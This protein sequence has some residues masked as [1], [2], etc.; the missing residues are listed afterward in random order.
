MTFRL[1]LIIEWFIIAFLA[2]AVVIALLQWDVTASFD[3]LLYDGLSETARPPVDEDIIIIAIDDASLKEFGKWPWGR[4]QH[5]KTIENIKKLGPRSISLDI[6]LSET[7]DIESDTLLSTAL[8]G[9]MQTQVADI[10]APAIFL[11]LHFVTPGNEGRAFDTILPAAPFLKRGNK[12][13]NLGHVNL[14]FDNDGI[15]RKNNICF[16]ASENSPQWPHLMERIYQNRHGKPSPAMEKAVK[17]TLCDAPVLIPFSESGSIATLSYSDA[18]KGNIL[19]EFVRGKDVIIG[20]TAAGLGDNYPTPSSN[21]SL[22]PGVEII[23]NMLG[24]LERDDFITPLPLWQSAL[25]SLLLIW[26]LLIGFLRWQPRLILIASGVIFFAILILSATFLY[27]GYWFPPGPALAALLLAYPLW[28]WRRLQAISYYMSEKLRELEREEDSSPLGLIQKKSIDLVGK[29]RDTLDQ[30]IDNIRDLRRFVNDTLFGLPDPMFVVNMDN[31]VILSNDILNQRIDSD[32]MGGDLS[33][34]IDTLVRKEDRA[35]VWQYIE[36][37]DV[38]SANAIIDQETVVR[39]TDNY[40]SSYVRFTSPRGRNFVM[41]RVPLLDSENEYRGHIHYL[42]DITAL[43]RADSQR[44]EMLQLLSH[45][46]RAPQ[47]AI[48]ALIDG[49]IDEAAKKSIA[50]NSKRTLQLAQDFV[51]IAR[52]GETPFDGEELL[53][54]SLVE[55]VIDSLWPLANERG[56]KIDLSNVSEGSFVIGEADSLSRAFMNLLDNAIKFSPDKSDIH[57]KIK[58][59]EFGKSTMVSITIEDQG[60]GIDSDML[61]ILFEKFTTNRGNEGR[62]QGTGLGLSFVSAVIER[63]HGSISADNKRDGGAI[64]SI[65]IPESLENEE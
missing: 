16:Q 32:L 34:A 64:F 30:A 6:I 63:H 8:Y 52:M 26:I 48:L 33:N 25:L 4:D 24:A 29:Q 61:P 12:H 28:G 49:D 50:N 58:N 59:M 41:R 9:D 31:E 17:T 40:T 53:I 18:A 45:D 60:N 15:L 55:E 1:R 43:A 54:D 13:D 51:E 21:G 14:S 57:V 56:I 46:M 47:S 62:A 2:N 20:A 23:A 10:N 36:T 37:S 7:G 44:E 65:L 42:A 35:L 27:F 38:D 39:M 5:A 3:N 11:P 22:M 19:P